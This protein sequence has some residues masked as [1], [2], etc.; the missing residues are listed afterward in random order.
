LALVQELVK[1]HDGTVGVES[2]AGQGTTFT[3]TVP[4]GSAHLP[5]ERRQGARPLASTA[6]G[7]TPY[8]EEALRWL[9]DDGGASALVD[10]TKDPPIDG[11]P[12][13]AGRLLVADDNQDMREYLQRL[14]AQY[15]EVEVVGDGEAALDAVRRTRPDLVLT[16][17]MMPKLDGFGV[18]R[19]LR[20]DPATRT[21]PVVLL[22][23]RAG[24]ESRVD[25]FDAGADDYLTK[26]FAARELLARVNVHLELARIRREAELA[27][28]ESEGRFRA[29]VM[30][31][32]DL[33]YRMNPDWTEMRF[34][35]DRAF[36][37]DPH[38]P[39][40]SWMETYIPSGDQPQVLAA[41]REAIRTKSVFQLE[42][43]VRRLDGTLG[44]TFSRAIPLLDDDGEIVE[45][46]GA[47]S[48]V[49]RRKEAEDALR[50]QVAAERLAARET[51]TLMAASRELSRAFALDEVLRTLCRVSRELVGADGAA[52]IFREGDQV[53]YAEEDSIGP[54]WKGRSFPADQCLSGWAILQR[55]TI[56]IEDIYAHADVPHDSYRSTFVRAA[57]LTPVLRAEPIGALGLYWRSSYRPTDAQVR[58]LETLADV[59]AIAVQNAQLFHESEESNRRKD[60][61]LAM[62][63][64]ELRNPLAP[65]M[66]AVEIIGALASREPHLERA[67]E[68]IRRQ[69]VHMTRLIDDLLDV[70]RITRGRI[71]LRRERLP[72]AEIV[73]AALEATRPLVERHGHTLALNIASGLE[74]DG[75]RARLVQVLTN[76]LANA[77]KFTPPGGHIAV[78]A[79]G[80]GPD[81][82]IAVRD[83]GIGIAKEAQA[84]IF[85]LFTQEDTSVERTQGGLGIG[86]TLAARLV[87]MH[88]GNLTV[89]SDGI[90]KGA[91]FVVTLP[92][93]A[94]ADTAEIADPG[95]APTSGRRL[96][97]LVVE[98]NQD[99]AESFQWLLELGGHT[100]EVAADGIQALRAIE[101]FRPDVA[102]VDL[103]LPG[104]DGFGVAER[105]RSRGGEPPLLVALSGYGREE[106]KQ[107][108]V[109]A[110]FDHHLTKPIEHERVQALL[111]L[112]GAARLVKDGSKVL[113]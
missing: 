75:D 94:S 50:R 34:L 102:F 37:P 31:S 63:A 41:I 58:L 30:A 104:I 15:W 89:R 8:V 88:D 45:W 32:S 84:R 109:E 29:L 20:A 23:A 19:A 93:L 64:H 25:G 56:V 44:W 4:T 14:L 71:E 47:A 92:A 87:A 22:S 42:H 99:A 76:L 69:V 10:A 28:R 77:A 16:D 1:L 91:E 36:I 61:F 6:T 72:L 108:A 83:T 2:T 113:Q 110:G 98:D 54:L 66:N 21:L 85:E 101:V 52:F 5:A 7:A 96:R 74:V 103:G 90:G 70:S 79:S 59:G 80:H 39:Q 12:T 105:V 33:V 86:L 48:D 82:A 111:G 78:R 46:F 53:R 38:E 57:A 49:T 55:E 26:P 11:I 35:E 24:E 43:R 81:A 95:S 68:I 100:V 51:T 106:D 9:P 97:V 27:V 62:L 73:D 65:V 40:K 13:A 3:V 60:E 67:G 18:L 17:V 107:R 112:L